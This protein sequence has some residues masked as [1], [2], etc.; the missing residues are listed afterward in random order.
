MAVGGGEKPDFAHAP[1]PQEH[2]SPQRASRTRLAVPNSPLPLTVPTRGDPACPADPP[3]APSDWLRP[4]RQFP[5]L[6]AL[7]NRETRVKRMAIG[8]V[9]PA[10]IFPLVNF[11]HW[12]PDPCCP[13]EQSRQERRFDWLMCIALGS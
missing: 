7:A 11:C 13:V 9:L 2:E 5:F 10:R 4:C 12:L 1:A 3:P 8:A 6:R